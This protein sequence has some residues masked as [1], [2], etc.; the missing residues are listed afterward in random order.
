MTDADEC[1]FSLFIIFFIS[2]RV[3][4][5]IYVKKNTGQ[6]I[7][8]KEIRFDFSPRFNYGVLPVESVRL[9]LSR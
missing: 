3:Y 4:L 5:C 6:S 9:S 8:N 1:G 7:S 2:L